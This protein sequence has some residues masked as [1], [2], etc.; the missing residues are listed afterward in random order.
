MKASRLVSSIT[1]WGWDTGVLDTVDPVYGYFCAVRNCIAH[2]SGRASK[3]LVAAAAA[4]SLQQ[5]LATWHGKDGKR[6]PPL[7]AITAH[8]DV[9]VLPRHVILASEACGRITQDTNAKLITFLGTE[10]IVYMAA[11]H[12]LLSGR[13]LKT[14]AWN[15][16]EAMLHVLL[17]N[18]Y[19]VKLSSET[20]A[21][22]VLRKLDKWKQYKRTFEKGREQTAL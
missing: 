14:E 6:V 5:C 1:L 7:P 19:Q 16:P 17:S 11:H 18:R 4:S 9:A 10:G 21:I 2:R 15:S 3:K 22:Q 20:E 13:P 8:E 12:S